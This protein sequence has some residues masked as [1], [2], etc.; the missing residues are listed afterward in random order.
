MNIALIRKIKKKILRWN[1]TRYLIIG[2][3]FVMQC[4]DKK[5]TL[6]RTKKCELSF[7][8]FLRNE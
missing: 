2:K 3:M 5:G 7:G 6:I 8:R 1:G 4:G